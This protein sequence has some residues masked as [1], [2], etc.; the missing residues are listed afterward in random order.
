MT[1]RDLFDVGERKPV[2]EQQFSARSRRVCTPDIPGTGPAD[3][4]CKTCRHLVHR[5]Q[6]N[7]YLKCGLMRAH[8]TNGG[9][10]DIRAR[11][12][13]CSKYEEADDGCK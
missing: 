13:A 3:K 1:Q 4:T 12:P 10:T 11:W 2:E 7:V 9:G 8:W 6:A 5:Q